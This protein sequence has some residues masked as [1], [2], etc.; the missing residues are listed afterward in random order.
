MRTTASICEPER[1]IAFARAQRDLEIAAVD[2]PDLDGH[3]EAVFLPAGF[4]EAGH[5]EKQGGYSRR[6]ICWSPQRQ[7]RRSG[8]AA[9]RSRYFPLF[10]GAEGASLGL[11]GVVLPLSDL[12][13]SPLAGVESPGVALSS[14]LDGPPSGVFSLESFPGRESEAPPLDVDFVSLKLGPAL[15]KYLSEKM[16][17]R[18]QKAA[19]PIVIFVNKSPAFVPNAKLLPSHPAERASQPAAAPALEQHDENQEAGRNDQQQADQDVHN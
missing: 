19:T 2:R 1:R 9:G 3:G 13:A 14:V 16:Q 4:A 11:G 17:R 12:L 8:S 7:C 15:L 6:L 18:I 5:A 10:G